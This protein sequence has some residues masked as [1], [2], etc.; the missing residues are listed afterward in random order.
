MKSVYQDADAEFVG[1]ERFVHKFI[2]A[3]EREL[4]RLELN[5]LLSTEDEL[6]K[7]TLIGHLLI[8]YASN[9]LKCLEIERLL[10]IFNSKK[11][12]ANQA[13]VLADFSAL[14]KASNDL[15]E[16]TLR[17][18]LLTLDACTAKIRLAVSQ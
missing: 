16:T 8:S 6:R 12:L 5:L 7:W 9:P 17:E 13:Q 18:L 2:R 1:G 14:Q 10:S 15:D 3:Q 4:R 11:V